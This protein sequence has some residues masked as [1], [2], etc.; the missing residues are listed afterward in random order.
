M[1]LV[2]GTKLG[3]Y[4]IVEP[5]GAGGM[6]E[7]YCGRDTRLGRDV[8]LKVLPEAFAGDMER[9]TRFERE[10]RV[11]ASLNHPNIA[12]T[13]GLEETNGTRALV[14]E[15]VERP[16]LA[17]RIKG[18]GIPLE[19]ALPIAKQICEG[20]EYAHERGV[21][22]R[23]LKPSNIKLTPDGHVKILDFGLAKAL[24]DDEPSADISSSPTISSLATQA[25][26]ILG[27]AA[28]MSP[29]QAKGK[30]V[31]RRADIWAFGCVLY[32]MLI[33]EPAFGGETITDVLAAVVRADPE[34]LLLPSSVP[35]RVRELLRRCLRK[36][37]KQRLR[38]IGEARIAIDEAL[39]GEPDVDE[40]AGQAQILPRKSWHR[41]LPW[42]LFT[43]VMLGVVVIIAGYIARSPKPAPLIISQI[44]PPDNANFVITGNFGGPP[45]LSPDGKQL[46]FVAGGTE[47]NARLW[48]RA[49]AAMT[50][51]PLEG[52]EG[53]S[54][55][56]WSPDS[57]S[58]GFF[59]NGKLKRIDVTGG[60]S[61]AL[62]DAPQARGG[63]WGPD[64]TILYTPSTID[65]IY[66]VAASGGLPQ[67]VTKLDSI[68][69][70]TSHRWPQFL[71]DGKHFLFFAHANVDQNN[72]TYGASLQ[73]GAPELLVHGDSSGIY[74]APGYL[75]FI[76]EGTL[77]AQ[78][79]DADAV[80]MIG[81]AVP[82]TE[83]ATSDAIIW[84]G[85]LSASDDGIMVYRSQSRFGENLRLLWFDRTGKQVGETGAAG[86]YGTLSLSPDASKLAV[87]R[88]A[89]GASNL[90]TWVY[91]LGRGIPT[92]L[93][94]S[95]K[96]A[97][98]P[99]W[100]PDGR[101]VAFV[102]NPGQG[103]LYQ[104]PADGT[105][106][107]SPLVVD[108]GQESRPSFS[109]DGRYLI[110][111]RQTAQTGSHTEIWSLP[112][113]GDRKPFPV[114]QSQQFDLHEPALSPNGKWLAYISPESGQYE[115]YLVPFIHG[116]GKWLVSSAG[117]HF[118]RWRRDG[119]ELFYLS[120]DNKIMSAEIAEKGASVVIGRL[121]PLFKANPSPTNGWAYDVSADGKKFVI[122]TLGGLEGS[123]PLTLV[124]NWPALLKKE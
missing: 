41:V 30:A 31:D 16:T 68:R 39:S 102:S 95:T 8:A 105:G 23:D 99:C 45:M 54:F 14:M 92:R 97:G 83:H 15:L 74:A 108:D 37:P 98:Q 59:A 66:R 56:F 73:G 4:E 89:P 65:P 44:A 26:I 58:I 40:T 85:T 93:T 10:A 61:I 33:G 3:P 7:V 114:A 35:M 80:R 47:G 38:D 87:S 82:V 118:P 34:W 53:A 113:F 11:L 27:T 75:L 71:P 18:E 94:F 90:D 91:D 48:V 51:Q 43:A 86:N 116:S 60:P 2:S 110:F 32:E 29:E 1:P 67:K 36:D 76:R 17:E 57:R 112:L 50:A 6:G 28:Y 100:S 20:L 70:E 46:A 106:T 62:A 78:R 19:E 69:L 103:H 5:L 13:Y 12:S 122:D 9:M 117:G 119:K 52:T 96:G 123:Q 84:R 109:S 64:G 121:T 104:K 63:S 107:A 111:E 55:P 24:E 79:F 81:E 25:G 72:A 101:T 124:V 22:H 49:L 42:A 77:M 88:V 120:L 21:I 115:V